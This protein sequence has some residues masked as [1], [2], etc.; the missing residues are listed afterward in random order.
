VLLEHLKGRPIRDGVGWY[1]GRPPGVFLQSSSSRKS[2]H[3]R[4]R[5]DL[6]RS[7]V[8][9]RELRRV[10]IVESHCLS[11]SGDDIMVRDLQDSAVT[12]PALHRKCA[13]PPPTGLI[14][15]LCQ[16]EVARTGGCEG[17]TTAA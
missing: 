2:F 13:I 4:T 16:S 1:V 7:R 6:N 15:A 12:G 3:G 5:I 9:I 14:H 17:P 8:Q 11:S 10:I